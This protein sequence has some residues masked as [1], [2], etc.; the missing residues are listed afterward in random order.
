[1]R[2]AHA[3]SNRDDARAV[4]AASKELL[5]TFTAYHDTFHE[6]TRRGQ[7]RFETRDW[8]GAQADAAERLALYRQRVHWA[9]ETLSGLLDAPKSAETWSAMKAAFADAV[10]A[11]ADTEIAETFF[12][13]VARRMQG[14]VGA[15]P[16]TTFV[17]SSVGTRTARPGAMYATLEG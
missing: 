2:G 7:R 5:E 16:R 17:E 6:I 10:A 3:R 12:N 11:R 4:E 1:M 13:S 15:D 9:V 14:T 8:A